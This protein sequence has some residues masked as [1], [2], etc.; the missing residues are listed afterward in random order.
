MVDHEDL[1]VENKNAQADEN[2]AARIDTD[3]P[4]ILSIVRLDGVDYRAGDEEKLQDALDGMEGDERRD[5]VIRHLTAQHAIVGF[6]GDHSEVVS[7]D[8]TLAASQRGRAKGLHN[9]GASGAIHD[10]NRIGD[11]IAA[12]ARPAEAPRQTNVSRVGTDE[13]SGNQG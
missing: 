13:G 7:A 3:T 8:P 2:E 9:V 1:S 10:V 11:T 6:G 12:G 5:G 4:A